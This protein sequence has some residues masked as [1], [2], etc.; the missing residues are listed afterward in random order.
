MRHLGQALEVAEG[1]LE[2]GGA[3]NSLNH[4]AEPST[5]RWRMAHRRETV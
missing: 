3:G 4:N 1:V 2:R 5:D